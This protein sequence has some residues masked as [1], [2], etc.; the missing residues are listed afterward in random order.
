MIFL[1]EPLTPS[2]LAGGAAIL[3][4][5]W[6]VSNAEAWRTV[7]TAPP[8]VLGD[9]WLTCPRCQTTLTRVVRGGLPR[10]TCAVRSHHNLPRRASDTVSTTAFLAHG[11]RDGGF[12]ALAV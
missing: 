9:D 7:A 2:L 11:E 4:G 10:P 3:T 6:L 8:I 1:G 5:V 12:L